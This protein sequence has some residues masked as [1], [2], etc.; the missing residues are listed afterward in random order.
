VVGQAFVRLLIDQNLSAGL[1]RHLAD[2]FPGSRHVR[3]FGLREGADAEIA[4]VASREGF[5]VL[6]KD[7][8]FARMA[9]SRRPLAKV[10]LLRLG[11]SSTAVVEALLRSRHADILEFSADPQRTV[12]VLP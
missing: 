11:N 9:W 3:D 6:T 12:F 2:V 8:D 7:G 10:I 1:A 5:V 4:E